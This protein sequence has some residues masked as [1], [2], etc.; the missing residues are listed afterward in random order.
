MVKT[1]GQVASPLEQLYAE[2]RVELEITSRWSRHESPLDFDP[3]EVK[4]RSIIE[5]IRKSERLLPPG[6]AKN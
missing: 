2:A 1:Y 6:W 3:V 5:V 4:D